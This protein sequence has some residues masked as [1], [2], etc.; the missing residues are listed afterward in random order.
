[1][2]VPAE[3][4]DRRELK[5]RKRR[6]RCERKDII[7]GYIILLGRYIILMSKIGK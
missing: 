2:K 6:E 1:M 3:V 7:L 4:A 5:I